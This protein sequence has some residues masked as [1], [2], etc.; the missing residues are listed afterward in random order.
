MLILGG[1]EF[2]MSE[3]PLK[4]CLQRVYG[5]RARHKLTGCVHFFSFFIALKPSVE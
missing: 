3:V 4:L 2:L 5:L 1:C